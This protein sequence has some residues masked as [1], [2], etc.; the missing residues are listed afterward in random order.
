MYVYIYMHMYIY[1]YVEIYIHIHM[2]DFR[3]LYMCWVGCS[4]SAH[5]SLGLHPLMV[6]QQTPNAPHSVME[7]W[8]RFVSMVVSQNKGTPI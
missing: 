6:L 8:L 2:A 5:G 3:V 1:I 4:R 7:P